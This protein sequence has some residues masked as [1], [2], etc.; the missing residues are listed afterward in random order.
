[1]RNKDIFMGVGV[2]A[3]TKRKKDERKTRKEEKELPHI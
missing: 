2:A 1:M 3:G